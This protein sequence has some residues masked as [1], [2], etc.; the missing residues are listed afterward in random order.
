MDKEGIID[1]IQK[2]YSS[3]DFKKVLYKINPSFEE[4]ENYENKEL[5]NYIL[6]QLHN[7]LNFLF[8]K[9]PAKNYNPINIDTT[10]D[11]NVFNN[12][13]K[14]YG[15]NY[16]SQISDLFYGVQKITLRCENCQTS[17]FKYEL[18]SS[19]VFSLE[20]V[21]NFKKS[22]M[23]YDDEDEEDN[24]GYSVLNINDL[25]E[26][27]FRNEILEND[28]QI[29]CPKCDSMQNMNRKKKI[30]LAPHTLIFILKRKNNS[31]SIFVDILEKLYLSTF[32]KNDKSP[33]DYKLIGTIMDDG[34]QNQ[35]YFAVCK[36]KIDDNWYKYN[37][38]EVT[39]VDFNDFRDSGM[40]YVL[41]Y[42]SSH[43]NS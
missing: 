39:K 41:I 26:Y 27:Y 13:L 43:S 28:D 31:Q 37:D 17:Q 32:V 38:G 4:N 6:K 25:L 22:K 11:K 10:S 23:K 33:K 21:K 36:C 16:R 19:L 18:F 7:E 12:F 40:P 8:S 9:P 2:S 3:L 42:K 34:E 14:T 35:H 1:D 15:A 5:I 30:F 24:E 29:L 20:K